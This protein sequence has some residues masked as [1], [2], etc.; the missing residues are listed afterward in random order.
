MTLAVEQY[1]RMVRLLDRKIPV[2]VELN[3]QARFH[4]ETGANGFNVIA[5]LPGTDP[6]PARW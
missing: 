3:V 4:D 2:K 6:A 5:D 1:N